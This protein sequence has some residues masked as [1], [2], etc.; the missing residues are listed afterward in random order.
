MCLPTP[1]QHI[2]YSSSHG[3]VFY[4]ARRSTLLCSPDFCTCWLVVPNLFNHIM[5]FHPRHDTGVVA[6]PQTRVVCSCR[7]LLG[8]A[9]VFQGGPL[10]GMAAGVHT[11]LACYL[12]RKGSREVVLAVCLRWI[13]FHSVHELGVASL[14]VT[15]HIAIDVGRG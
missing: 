8:N 3:S 15:T 14:S 4:D 12:E 5:C 1:I 2:V 10:L 7:S 9:R 11:D 6:A 13:I